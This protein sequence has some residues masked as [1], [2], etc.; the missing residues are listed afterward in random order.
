MNRQRRAVLLAGACL[1]AGAGVLAYAERTE[2]VV[3]LTGVECRA[4]QRAYDDGKR[5]EVLSDI[6]RDCD[7]SGFP[8][9]R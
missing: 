1:L 9:Q 6:L 4:A 8:V 3:E 7:R 5:D 2:P